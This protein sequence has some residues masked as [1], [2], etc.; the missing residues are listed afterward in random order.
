MGTRADFYV[1]K[2][3]SAEWI[4]S[5]AWDGYREGLDPQILNCTSE[6]AFRH[7]VESFFAERKDATRP[8]D[9]WP[10][11]WDDSGIT[12]CTYSFFDGRCW[13]DCGGFYAPCDEE[14]PEDD[15][16]RETWLKGRDEVDYPNMAAR[17]KLT[18]GPRSGL[19]VFGT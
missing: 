9:G 8:A 3:K 5:I 12:D 7:A 6:A 17:K 10:W 14:V 1:G 11:P 19:M 16:A 13:D 4:G 15:E 18:L 2:G